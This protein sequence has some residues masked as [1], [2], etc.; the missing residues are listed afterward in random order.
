MAGEAEVRAVDGDRLPVD[1][2]A[3]SRVVPVAIN[4]E[5]EVSVVRVRER[6]TVVQGLEAGEVLAVPLDEVGQLVQQVAPLR[7]VHGAPRASQLE[8]LL[9][10]GHGLVHVSLVALGNVAYLFPR[11]G[12]DG[13]ECGP[14]HGIV[15]RVVDED[16][17]VFDV[18]GTIEAWFLGVWVRHFFFALYCSDWTETKD[19]ILIMY[20]PSTN[21]NDQKSHHLLNIILLTRIITSGSKP[22]PGPVHVH[23][24]IDDR[25]CVL[26]M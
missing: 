26:C 19:F 10:C 23:V 3:P 5:R 24:I 2:V 21:R 6:L 18:R 16:L 9:R 1:L 22:G 15:P 12:V 14:T 13:G 25:Y 7:G 8:R 11:A 20:D 4:H 17:R